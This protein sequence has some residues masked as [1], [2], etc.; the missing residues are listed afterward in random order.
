MWPDE[1]VTAV[2]QDSSNTQRKEHN[3]KKLYFVLLCSWHEAFYYNAKALF[4]I[5]NH[6]PPPVCRCSS[7]GCDPAGS[8]EGTLCDPV[9]GVCSCKQYVTG[10]LCDSC[11]PGFQQ[12]EASNPLGCSARE[13]TIIYIY[14]VQ[15]P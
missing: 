4:L 7:C 8:V 15:K 1:G 5:S 14:T 6:L 3:I 2:Y 10:T 12:L 9:T 11:V 13:W